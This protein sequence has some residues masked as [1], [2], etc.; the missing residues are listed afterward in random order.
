MER[1]FERIYDFTCLPQAGNYELRMQVFLSESGFAGFKD[2]QDKT[3]M[4]NKGY[5]T[6]TKN[7]GVPGVQIVRAVRLSPIGTPKLFIILLNF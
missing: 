5:F 7:S 2:K 4:V 6:T 3:V 1:K